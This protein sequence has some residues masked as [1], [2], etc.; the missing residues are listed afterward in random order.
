MNKFRVL[1]SLLIV[2]LLAVGFVT[3]CGGSDDGDGSSSDTGSVSGTVTDANGDPI[4]GAT[5]TIITTDQRAT[6]EATTNANGVFLING[7]PSGTWTLTIT[8]DGFQTITLNITVGSGSTTE[9]PGSE[10]VVIP[11]AGT[12][13]VTG[14]VSDA[15]TT[16]AIE[17]A[18]VVIGSFSAT[19]SATGAYILPAVTAGAQTITATKTGYESY[20]ST[21]T[22]VAD[23]TVTRD[24]AMT[25]SAPE[26]GK[27]HING[28]VIDENGNALSGV[29]VTAGTITDT[30]DANG[31][32]TLMNL[33]PGAAT[34][35]FAKT[36]YDNATVGVTVV[37]DQT[38]TATTVTMTTGPTTGTTVLCSVPR[39]TEI[40]NEDREAAGRPSN[41]GSVSDNGAF[42]AFISRQPL[43]AIHIT[44]TTHA[45]LFSRASGT[46]TMM[47]VDPNGL[48]GTRR[49][50]LTGTVDTFISGDASLIAYSTNESN[51]LGTGMDAN[52]TYDVFVYHRA[53]GINSRV[54]VDYSNGSIGGYSN[55][56]KTT[57]GA[58]QNC[59]LSQDGGYVVFDSTAKNIVAPG[60][61]TDTANP[62]TTK[63]VFRVKLTQAADGTV[64][65]SAPLLVSAR[66]RDGKECLPADWGTARTSMNPFVSRD[67]RFVVYESNALPGAAYIGVG[68]QAAGSALINNGVIE[69]RNGFTPYRDAGNDRDIII[70]DTQDTAQTRTKF[71]SENETQKRQATG[72]N[73]CTLPTV[74]DDGKKVAFQCQDA[75]SAWVTGNDENMDIWLKNLSD[76]TLTR[77]S[78]ASS[79]ARG[80]SKNPMVSRDGTMVAFDSAGT[81]FVQNDTNASIDCFVYTVA[82][83]TFARVNLN[84]NNDQTDATGGVGSYGPFLSGDNNYVTFTSVAKNLTSN[85]YFTAGV[86]DVYLR[87]WQ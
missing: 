85:V 29:T 69:G 28:K 34:V 46:V 40:G 49:A 84:S 4:S 23:S 26:P 3:G 38:V 43:V 45:Y 35:S 10:T 9:I 82:N 13:I 14:T 71:V 17:G 16:V 24:I 30:T 79:G 7:V 65:T 11:S 58:S 50:E 63:N 6:F 37:A 72:A 27:G 86:Q 87:K 12:G 44:N 83:G 1:L 20:T 73:Y 15:T 68:G 81:G 25:S 64:T 59:G 74:S 2:T 66:Q 51:I 21:V 52:G 70:C 22:V 56:T 60:I 67:G 76:G 77:V 39:T 19:S 33:T 18:T 78:N 32:Y 42:V 55:D 36:G 48:E 8:K 47:D 61:I 57:G 31:E 5:C 62:H 53:T 54:S 80:E 41:G 75:L